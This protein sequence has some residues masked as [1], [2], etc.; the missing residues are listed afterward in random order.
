LID[1]Y[2][3]ADPP[4]QSAPGGGATETQTVLR[5]EEVSRARTFAGAAVVL[6]AV[7]L[8]LHSMNPRV[9]YVHTAMGLALVLLGAVAGFVW[10]Y[11]LR[12]T[13]LPRPLVRVFG[14]TGLGAVLA[15]LLY[16][17][18]FSP[19]AVVLVFGISFFGLGERARIIVQDI[20]VA[21]LLYLALALA[22]TFDLVPDF[23][24]FSASGVPRSARLSMALMVGSLCFV[25]LWQARASRRATT[26]AIERAAEAAR[27]AKRCEAQLL[28]AHQDIEALRA[29][30]RGRYTGA[31]VGS[32]RLAEIIGRGAMGEVYAATHYVTGEPAAVKLLNVIAACDPALVQR[33]LREAEISSGL[34]GENLV[35][36]YEVGRAPDGAAYIAMERLRG[37][38]LGAILRSESRLSVAEALTLVDDVARGLE[39]AHAAGVVHRDLKPANVFLAERGRT[40]TWTVLDFGIAKPGTSSGTLT[41]DQ[42]VGTPGYMSPEQAM[43]DDGDQRADVFSLGAV[44]YRALTGRAP[45]T[46]NAT[47]ALHAVVF[48]APPAPRSVAPDLHADVER[49]IAIALAKKAEDR[50]ESAAELGVAL[51]AAS[52]GQLGPRLR[53]R[54]ERLIGQMPWADA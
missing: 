50:F 15:F 4:T 47:R 49:V 5:S 45:F 19:V 54:G 38:D 22:M 14:L 37:R 42:I 25:T 48:E 51:R 35:R 30:G 29:N 1:A 53:A 21:T 36:V 2:A 40:A 32:W 52:V 34:T 46:G 27:V 16:M 24:L 20:T 26:Q 12:A 41:H 3:V 43:G 17:G 33:F 10:F 18:P 44:A 8:V 7:G 39:I 11:T 28:E 23:G 6:C 9:P 13:A 31:T